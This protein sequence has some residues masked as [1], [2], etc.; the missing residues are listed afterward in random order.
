MRDKEFY[1]RYTNKILG[2]TDSGKKA[3]DT[4]DAGRDLSSKK[5][6][7]GVISE[8]SNQ[9]EKS[10]QY[11]VGD[12]LKKKTI[13]EL[14][15]AENS[16]TEN[17]NADAE[18]TETDES[19]ENDEVSNNAKNDLAEQW[20]VIHTMSGKEE[21]LMKYVDI[22]VDR[23]YVSECFVPKRERK[24]KV[25]QQWKVITEKIF[26]GYVFIVTSCSEKVFFALKNVP[27]LS[28]ILCDGEFT[29]IPLKDNEINFVN[30]IG[31]GRPDHTAKISTVEFG[32]GDDV[33]YMQGDVVAFEGMIKKFDKHRRRAVVET[34]MFGQKTEIW[35][36]FEYLRKKR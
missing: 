30:R 36:E 14:G 25:N 2:R 8:I 28:K 23:S 18:K 3:D 10:E 6:S 17:S 22:F 1:E 35:L 26:K 9:L 34:E 11:H 16:I 7:G 32:E 19:A 27:M 21:V 29:F 12:V 15:K 20:Y 5:G 33:L 4:W 24:K 31:S 13:G